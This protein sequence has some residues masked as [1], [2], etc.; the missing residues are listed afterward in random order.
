MISAHGRPATQL[1]ASSMRSRSS[2]AF[3]AAAS[4]SS[5]SST[6]TVYGPAS[7]NPDPIAKARYG[8][9]LGC[10]SSSVRTRTRSSGVAS[11]PATLFACSATVNAVTPD[12]N[13]AV[14]APL[15]ASASASTPNSSRSPSDGAPP[16]AADS[17]DSNASPLAAA[18]RY[19]PCAEWPS[20]ACA[21]NAAVSKRPRNTCTESSP[22]R[23]SWSTWSMVNPSPASVSV[24]RGGSP[25]IPES[26][27][28]TM[29]V[30]L[31]S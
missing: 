21:I 26:G 3:A 28:G 15:P 29:P 7:S 18:Y 10:A 12:D 30:R 27:D 13:D 4:A 24:R 22:V 11:A 14:Y 5:C 16:A 9:S 23:T 1:V 31:P 20:S 2:G 25:P 19:S 17:V 8:R 6:R